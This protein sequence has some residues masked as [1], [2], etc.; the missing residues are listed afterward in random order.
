M[1]SIYKHCV[2]NLSRTNSAVLNWNA[3]NPLISRLEAPSNTAIISDGGSQPASI[4]NIY[5]LVTHSH[6]ANSVFNRVDFQSPDEGVWG[7]AYRSRL[8]PWTHQG[9]IAGLSACSHFH[10]Q[11]SP[12][13]FKVINTTEFKRLKKLH[14]LGKPG[15]DCSVS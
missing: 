1:S 6:G 14:Q 13:A 5:I 3:D 7:L 2:A 10:L 9:K 12:L 11:L 15:G 8:C 4:K